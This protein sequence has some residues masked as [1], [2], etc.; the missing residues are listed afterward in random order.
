V[1]GS[2]STVRTSTTHATATGP[3]TCYW[4]TMHKGL[5]PHEVRSSPCRSIAA[6]AEGQRS[7]LRVTKHRTHQYRPS[8]RHSTLKRLLMPRVQAPAVVRG[9]GNRTKDAHLARVVRVS[10]LELLESNEN[11]CHTFDSNNVE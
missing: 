4:S 2:P 7:G 9:T 5:R 1:C 10:S 8:H 11:K 6:S 3:S